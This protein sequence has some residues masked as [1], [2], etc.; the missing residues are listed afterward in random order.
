[1]LRHAVPL[2]IAAIAA[3]SAAARDASAPNVGATRVTTEYQGN[4]AQR[5]ACT[6][7]VFRLCAQNIPDIAAIRVCLQEQKPQLSPDC[8][9]VFDGRFR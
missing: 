4:D 2:V 9:A 6:S 5:M 7:D 1:M 8:R 3:G